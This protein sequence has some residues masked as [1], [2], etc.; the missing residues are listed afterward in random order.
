MGVANLT[1]KRAIDE[2]VREGW[3]HS[4]HGV[5]TF[6]RVRKTPSQII[7]TAPRRE[8]WEQFLNHEHLDAFQEAHPNVRV[9]LSSEPTTDFVVTNSYGLVTDRIRHHRLLSLD[10]LQARLGKRAWKLPTA[11]RAM[12]SW[13][14]EL[15]ALPM[16]VSLQLLQL[17]PRLLERFGVCP[18]ARYLD[19]ETY[20]EIL[21]RCRQDKDGDGIP[22]CAGSFA[23][24]FLCEWLVRF[25]QNGGRLDSREAFFSPKAFSVFDELWRMHHIDRTLPL[26]MP[27]AGNEITFKQIRRRFENEQIAIRWNTNLHMAR[28]FPFPTSI[29]LPRFGPVPRQQAH[30]ALIGIHRDCAH[31]EVAIE[32]L[33]FC[34]Q[35]HIQGNAE[36]PFA[37]EEE[38]RVLLRQ[39]PELHRLLAEGFEQASEPL[40][41]GVPERTWEIENE[42]FDWFRLFVD[43]PNLRARLETHWDRWANSS[44]GV[45]EGDP[46]VIAPGEEPTRTG[47]GHFHEN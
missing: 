30:A 27:I 3:L 11:V 31:P 16:R 10:A 34:Y 38:D 2:L 41:E 21:T 35:R 37:L 32:F 8:A 42:L 46:I 9:I 45:R 13:R 24:L 18:P 33:N 1:A 29:L 5:G 12:A 26:E 43:R 15:F 40:H 23:Q 17:N 20:Q 44:G 39:M 6:V 28:R 19:W 47:R 7:L 36:Y 4:R 14:G 25:W 22:E